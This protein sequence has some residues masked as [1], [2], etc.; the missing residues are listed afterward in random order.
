MNR[1]KLCEE[2]KISLDTSFR[3]QRQ[4]LPKEKVAIS[5]TSWRWDFNKVKVLAW[6][7]QR[8]KESENK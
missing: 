7:R 2:L 3:W 5:G 4:G 1:K 8:K 6:L